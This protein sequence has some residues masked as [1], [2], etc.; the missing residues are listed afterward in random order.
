MKDTTIEIPTKIADGR[1]SLE[2]IGILCVVMSSPNLTKEQAIQ[3]DNNK[4]LKQGLEGLAERGVVKFDKDENGDNILN[5]DIEP[6][7][8]EK[9]NNMNIQNAIKELRETWDLTHE[10]IGH[11]QELMEEVAGSTYMDGYND[12][13]VEEEAE[14]TAYGKKGDF[15]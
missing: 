12:R 7:E 6:K 1:F 15:E 11:I 2:E 8:V 3:W 5:I 14:F 13:R 4:D 10:E 9:Y